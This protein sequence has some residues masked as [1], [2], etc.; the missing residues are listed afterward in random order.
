MKGLVS[1]ATGSAKKV[2]RMPHRPVCAECN[3][4][5]I[6][7]ELGIVVVDVSNHRPHKPTHADLWKCPKCGHRIVIGF[8]RMGIYL[9]DESFGRKLKSYGEK[10]LVVGCIK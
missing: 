3:V 2:R 8:A 9:S 10:G 1:I 7:E 4:E 6:P 5:F